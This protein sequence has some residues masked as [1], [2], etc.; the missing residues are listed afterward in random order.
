MAI[1]ARR[2]PYL[3]YR[4]LVELE[5]LVVGGFSDV[6]GL[7]SEIEFFDYREG[8]VN[9]YIHKLW[10]P[11]RYPTNLTLKHGL[12]D[13]FD[14]W[15]WY[16]GITQGIILRRNLSILLLDDRGDEKIRWN[17]IG[18]YPV[19]WIGPELRA[20]S[21]AVTIETLELVHRGLIKI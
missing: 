1:G 3:A 21:A 15:L 4:F 11:T 17:F 20:G 2:D 13:R 12:T 10:G 14:L 7:Q 9:D 8:G 6:T 18:A 19:R 16:L 5:G